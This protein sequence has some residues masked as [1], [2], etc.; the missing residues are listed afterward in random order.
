MANLLR[1]ELP[2]LWELLRW[3]RA[4][5][6]LL[7]AFAATIFVILVVWWPLAEDYLATA[8]PRYPIW[9]QHDYLLLAVFAA[10][11]L[12]IMS[13]PDLKADARIVAVGLAGGLVIESWGTQTHL[14]ACLR[15]TTHLRP[16]GR[17][18]VSLPCRCRALKSP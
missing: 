7:S 11:T 14:C 10:M 4:S 2:A 15:Q 13:R 3:N 18:R 17:P 12:L 6:L 16:A 1:R 5:Y 9:Q 8:D